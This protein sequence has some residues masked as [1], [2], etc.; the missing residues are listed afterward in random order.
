M[1][2]TKPGLPSGWLKEG[3]RLGLPEPIMRQVAADVEAA[4]ALPTIMIQAAKAAAD[5]NAY[6]KAVAAA[7]RDL[8]AW[9][10]RRRPARYLAD[11]A[12]EPIPLLNEDEIRAAL[13]ST[14]VPQDARG[15]R[16]AA[17]PGIARNSTGADDPET[18][19]L[20]ARA[21][22]G[23]ADALLQL[24]RAAED[25]NRQCLDWLEAAAEADLGDGPC[26]KLCYFTAPP[27]DGYGLD[28]VT[29]TITTRRFN[30]KTCKYE[31]REEKKILRRKS[32]EK[33]ISWFDIRIESKSKRL[34]KYDHG[35]RTYIT[36]HDLNEIVTKSYRGEDLTLATR[37]DI[38]KLVRYG[39]PVI[40]PGQA[41]AD[42]TIIN[43]RNGLMDITTD[44]P[45]APHT[46]DHISYYQCP[47]PCIP[48]APEPE[49]YRKYLNTSVA[50]DQQDTLIETIAVGG[51]WRRGRPTHMSVWF[52]GRTDSGKTTALNIIQALRASRD[53]D[54]MTHQGIA[55]IT[56]HELERE[57]GWRLIEGCDLL[58]CDE[59][60][61]KEAAPIGEA[62]RFKTIFH[63]SGTRRTATINPKYREPY[64]MVLDMFG[65]FAMN[66]LNIPDLSGLPE[67]EVDAFLGRVNVVT[68][69]Y[70]YPKGHPERDEDLDA[71]LGAEM[72]GILNVLRRAL[73]RVHRQ[74][75]FS[76]T[77]TIADAKAVIKGRA[78]SAALFVGDQITI[79]GTDAAHPIR[80]TDL[81]ERYL[82]YCSGL[83]LTAKSAM[84]FNRKLESAGA[85]EVLRGPKGRRVKSWVH[86][87]LSGTPAGSS[88]AAPAPSDA[89]PAAPKLPAAAPPADPRPRPGLDPLAADIIRN[90]AVPPTVRAVVTELVAAKRPAWP[91]AE[92]AARYLRESADEGLLCII[93][94]MVALPGGD[95]PEA[96]GA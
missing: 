48:D 54:D 31:P 71:K 18:D 79:D 87:R 20:I 62:S 76:R 14:P 94:G 6:P 82:Q 25:G 53:P 3:L 13:A 63:A 86:V 88:R 23:D 33:L 15:G 24:S 58:I 28:P 59:T 95:P 56:I 43:I 44:D 38:A 11:P 74:G 65:I 47:I 64:P 2:D 73:H 8:L 75:G 21:G 41:D 34:S 60:K 1:P 22:A 96:A 17:A 35:V 83:K 90:M 70:S 57:D 26:R 55:A 69:D 45:P 51:L 78:D 49:P 50:A 68:F 37:L 19:A 7:T 5:H 10:C 61:T 93:R 27:E 77:T 30:P 84:V 42:P 9:D 29:E 40:K 85:K 36:L 91:D 46:R 39:A 80:K 89:A 67:E 52:V 4:V 16:D 92:A 12:T 66:T 72:P 32:A 81:Y